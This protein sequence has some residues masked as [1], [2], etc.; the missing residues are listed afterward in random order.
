[1]ECCQLKGYLKFLILWIL[2]KQSMN[3]TE[4]RKDLEKRRDSLPSPGTIYPALKELR[5]N[6]LIKVD[7]KK[8]YSLTPKGEKELK[9]SCK[10]FFKIFHDMEEMLNYCK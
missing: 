2:S 3:A 10:L 1:M 6:E 5:N 9:K 8:Y 4:I 7:E